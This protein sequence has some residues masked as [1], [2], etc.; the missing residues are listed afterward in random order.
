MKT[1]ILLSSLVFVL[2]ACTKTK[3]DLVNS[4][5]KEYVNSNCNDPSSYESIET[6]TATPVYGKDIQKTVQNTIDVLSF[7]LDSQMVYL[8]ENKDSIKAFEI[9]AIEMRK[10]KNEYE[11]LPENLLGYKVVD[12]FRA[13]NKL[14]ALTVETKY[15]YFDTLMNIKAVLDEEQNAD[16]DNSD[17][18]RGVYKN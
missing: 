9:K 18:F 14:G 4:K 17:I 11:S 2:L 10:R 12:K 1:I 16:A 7:P 5:I 6:G 3:D 13:K 8:L 15:Y